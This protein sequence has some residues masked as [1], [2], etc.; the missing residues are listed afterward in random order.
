M[1]FRIED[2]A[3]EAGVSTATV[4]RTINMPGKVKAATRRK[5]ELVIKRLG[6]A[7]NYFAQSLMKQ[8][9]GSVGLLSSYN[10]NPY[11]IEMIDAI[12]CTLSQQ[13]IYVYLCNCE[14]N[15][16]LEAKYAQEMIHR[17]IDA[18]IVLETPSL[19]RPDNYFLNNEF[20]CPVI[21]AN[22]HTEPFGN[23]Y[24]VRSDQAPGIN[25]VFAYAEEHDLFPFTHI[26]SSSNAYSYALKEQLFN[27]WKAKRGLSGKEARLVRPASLQSANTEGTVWRTCEAVGEMLD[28]PNRPRFIFA[29]NDLMAMGVMAAAAKLGLRVPEDLAVA[30]VD[31]T[32]LSR[33]SAPPLS[34]VDLRMRDVG[35][36]AAELYL[37]IRYEPEQEYPRLQPIPS[38]FLLRAST[39]G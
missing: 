2:I 5:V 4:S 34:T 12:E 27:K 17:N 31:N 32:L 3:R 21:I 37:S 28:A 39:P 13:G 29:G 18:L 16:E 14:D 1:N 24:I 38:R 22:Q 6:Y 20:R 19:N 36:M 10:M 25:E 15:R 23:H 35:T 7:P 8:H 9:S 26:I 30:G 33:I 11:I